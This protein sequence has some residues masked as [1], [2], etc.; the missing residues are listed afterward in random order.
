M[1]F[2]FISIFLVVSLHLALS[3][4]PSCLICNGITLSSESWLHQ[5]KTEEEA[6][7]L[8]R[9]Y[10]IRNPVIKTQCLDILNKDGKTLIHNVYFKNH[11]QDF[12][13]QEFGYCT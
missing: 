7:T 5:N 12:G 8:I 3:T 11:G 10:C 13:C 4:N 6:F 2:I 1:K 9:N